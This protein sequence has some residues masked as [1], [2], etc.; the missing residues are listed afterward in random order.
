MANTLAFKTSYA[1]SPLKY[2]SLLDVA[3][4]GDFDIVFSSSL[5]NS[6]NLC[7]QVRQRQTINPLFHDELRLMGVLHSTHVTPFFFILTSFI[8]HQ[9]QLHAMTN[10]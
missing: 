7:P 9:D 4:N 6:L 1:S 8:K 3:F 2:V 10:N 5:A